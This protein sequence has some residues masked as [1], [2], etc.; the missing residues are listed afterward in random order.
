MEQVRMDD[1]SKNKRIRL[2]TGEVVPSASHFVYTNETMKLDLYHMTNVRVDSS[3][4]IIS[5]FAFYC[6]A[7]LVQVELHA[8]L[9]RIE[10][11]AF[12]SCL[13]LSFVQF[14]ASD[15]SLE[16]SST[17]RISEDGLVVN[18]RWKISCKIQSL[19]VLLMDM[20]TLSTD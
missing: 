13:N 4:S 6:C 14:A 9:T 5:R 17:R 16:A 12:S 2:G 15:A 10:Q 7:K 11:Q 1:E 18:W 3:V 8:T 20:M 19:A